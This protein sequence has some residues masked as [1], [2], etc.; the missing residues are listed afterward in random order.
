MIEKRISAL[1]NRMESGSIPGA[2]VAGSS[3]GRSAGDWEMGNERFV[4][5]A[6]MNEKHNSAL[7]NWMGSGSI[8]G[9]SLV[10]AS[11]DYSGGIR[12]VKNWSL[13]R[14]ARLRLPDMIESEKRI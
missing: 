4:R 5:I 14:I 3:D 12:L 6:K 9:A 8:L 1:R 10:S 13:I 7:Q 11:D 2:S